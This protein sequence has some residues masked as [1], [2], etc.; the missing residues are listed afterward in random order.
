MQPV[1]YD[2]ERVLYSIQHREA[3]YFRHMQ[4]RQKNRFLMLNHKTSSL[5]IVY[6]LFGIG[7]RNDLGIPAIIPN[8]HFCHFQ[9]AQVIVKQYEAWGF[10]FEQ[11]FH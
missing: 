6:R 10:H 7:K 2:F 11:V 9:S 3:V 4:V 1:P 8:D 5:K